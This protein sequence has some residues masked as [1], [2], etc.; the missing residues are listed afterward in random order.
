MWPVLHG[1]SS[2]QL[3]AFRVISGFHHSWLSP[4]C[5]PQVTELSA[6][7]RGNGNIHAREVYYVGG[8]FGNESDDGILSYFHYVRGTRRAEGHNRGRVRSDVR[9]LAL[10]D[11]EGAVRSGRGLSV[12]LRQDAAG[13][14]R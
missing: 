11:G 12:D 14:A 8:C 3:I 5:T 2:P 7:A 9:P 6:V 10:A 1:A 13:D 4:L